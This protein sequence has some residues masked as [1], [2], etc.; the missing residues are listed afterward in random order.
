MRRLL[1]LI[2]VLFVFG[3]CTSPKKFARK[4]GQELH[5]ENSIMPSGSSVKVLSDKHSSFDSTAY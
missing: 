1:F 2:L 5:R 3:S 4:V